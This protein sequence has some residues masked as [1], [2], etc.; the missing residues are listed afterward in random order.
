[1]SNVTIEKFVGFVDGEGSFFIATTSHRPIFDIKLRW[2]DR[3]L[4]E[5][6]NK[7]ILGGL[8]VINH[9][10][11]ANVRN[12]K[13][14]HPKKAQDC[15]SLRCQSLRAVFKVKRIFDKHLLMSKKARDFR[16]WRAAVECIDQMT[17]GL[18]RDKYIL[19]Y[20][21]LLQRVRENEIDETDLPRLIK[22]AGKSDWDNQANLWLAA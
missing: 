8:G 10:S 13:T 21:H 18:T 5:N 6:F 17:A 7:E 1:M 16:V 12:G 20:H 14:K 2:D 3:L 11:E 4:L 22:E 9:I 19:R 15:V